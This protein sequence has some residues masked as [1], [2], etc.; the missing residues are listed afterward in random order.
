[1]IPAALSAASSVKGQVTNIYGS[2]A[3]PTYF[4]EL[5]VDKKNVIVYI[6]WEQAEFLCKGLSLSTTE[7]QGLKTN[8]SLSQKTLDS[9]RQNTSRLVRIDVTSAGK[10]CHTDTSKAG[11]DIISFESPTTK[12]KDEK[13]PSATEDPRYVPVR[14]P[15]SPT[16]GVR[17]GYAIFNNPINYIHQQRTT[18]LDQQPTLRENGTIKKGTGFSYENYSLNYY[19]NDSQEIKT[20]VQEVLEQV[21]LN[22]FITCE[23]G[24]FGLKKGEGDIP[25]QEFVVQGV[26][27]ATIPKQPGSLSVEL[28]MA[29][30]LFSW[31]C[32]QTMSKFVPNSSGGN[33]GP[34]LDMDD[35]I[36]WPLAKLWTKTR[37]KSIYP[38]NNSKALDGEFSLSIPSQ[39]VVN[40]LN[41]LAFAS[42]SLDTALDYNTLAS[43]QR[44]LETDSF[45][46]VNKLINSPNLKVLSARGH[47]ADEKVVIV[48]VNSKANFHTLLET[49]KSLF[50]GLVD[51]S[52]YRSHNF[53][54][55][56]GS[57]LPESTTVFDQEATESTYPFL[58][59][60]A[61]NWYLDIET[62]ILGAQAERAK[63]N[64]T[65]KD[66][67]VQEAQSRPWEFFALAFKVTSMDQNKLLPQVKKLADIEKRTQK[68]VF[69][70][71]RE[72]ITDILA[73]DTMPYSPVL[74]ANKEIIIDS[75]AGTRK[76]NVVPTFVQG[77]TLPSFEYLGGGS[78]EFVVRGQVFSLAAKKQI[79]QLKQ[80]FDQRSMR[81]PAGYGGSVKETYD[82]VPFMRVTNEV[83]D[84]F[85]VQ[86]V[87]P[88]SVSCDSVSEE[89]GVW[90]FELVLL[91]Y[92][93]RTQAAERIKFLPTTL[94]DQAKVLNY[95]GPTPD[96]TS[97]LVLK[98]EEFFSL[99]YSLSQ[100]EVYPD[101]RLP[102]RG[103]VDSWVSVLGDEARR[104]RDTKGA[105][106]KAP[107][108]SPL[109]AEW[110]EYCQEFLTTAYTRK[111]ITKFKEAT[112]FI[113]NGAVDIGGYVD[114]DFYLVYD[115]DNSW[116]KLLDKAMGIDFGKRLDNLE[117]TGPASGPVT[118]VKKFWDGTDKTGVA[119]TDKR[120]KAVYRVFDPLFNTYTEHSYKMLGS[121]AEVEN[122]Y[123]DATHS[124]TYP[125]ANR[126]KGIKVAKSMG[127]T[128]EQHPS[129]WWKSTV[130]KLDETSSSIVD[131]NPEYLEGPSINARI[132]I[133][134][135]GNNAENNIALVNGLGSDLH[136]FF[137]LKWRR[138]TLGVAA[139]EGEKYGT[140][141]YSRLTSDKIKNGNFLIPTNVYP[142]EGWLGQAT[143]FTSNI[144]S[145][146]FG[147]VDNETVRT[148]PGEALLLMRVSSSVSAQQER[149]NPELQSLEEITRIA[150][151]RTLKDRKD[152]IPKAPTTTPQEEIERVV[153][154]NTPDELAHVQK[155]LIQ[156]ANFQYPLSNPKKDFTKQSIT[157]AMLESAP[158][159]D[160]VASTHK[161]DP[162]VLRAFVL[163]R[164]GFGT[165]DPKVY[166]DD[167]GFAFLSREVVSNFDS[168]ESL[169]YLASTYARYLKEYNNIPTI[170]LTATYI[171]T[172]HEGRKKWWVGKGFA[173]SV[174]KA[175]K[176]GADSLAV[177]PYGSK[178]KDT[179]NKMLESIHLGPIM[180]EFW[181]G[182]VEVSR[183]L[184]SHINT[185]TQEQRDLFF[186]P[187]NPFILNDVR[188]IQSYVDTN[189]TPS[190]T[191]IRLDMGRQNAYQLNADVR[192]GTGK[193][194]T[195]SV[196][197][198]A[199]ARVRLQFGLSPHTEAALHGALLDVRTQGAFGRFVQAFPAHK[200][201]IINEG[202]FYAE[203][204]TKLWDQFYTRGGITSIEVF[205]SKNEPAH[206]AFVTFSNM[207][208]ALTRYTQMEALKQQISKAN[209]RQLQE[210]TVRGG[211]T[212]SF[213][214]F[215]HRIWQNMISKTPDPE[216][217]R[218]WQYNHLQQLA[219]SP[220]ARVQ[221]RMGYGSNA[222]TFPIVFNGR[223][224]EV[225]V[226]HG[227]VTIMAE[228]D[229]IELEKPIT[230]HLVKADDGY[231]YRSYVPGMWAGAFAGIGTEPAYI[232]ASALV[233]NN[234]TIAALTQGR[235]G[236]T[237]LA[238]HFGDI[239]FDN[240]TYS[241]PELV[242]NMYGASKKHLEQGFTY[243]QQAFNKNGLYN[244]SET[245]LIS[246]SV[247]E[248]TP[249]KTIQVCRRAVID[250]VASV[251]MFHTRST[252]FYG[253][254][255]YPFNYEFAPSILRYAPQSSN[256]PVIK[257]KIVMDINS[258]PAKTKVFSMVGDPYAETK[259]W[260]IE[261]NW[262]KENPQGGK[263]LRVVRP[264]RS[265]SK[266]V[267]SGANFMEG[268]LVFGD[269][270]S[271]RYFAVKTWWLLDAGKD[272]D[273][274]K[275]E[276]ITIEQ[277]LQI[278]AGIQQILEINKR[279]FDSFDADRA[280]SL[281]K[282]PAGKYYDVAD[283]TM[284]LEVENYVQHL[285]WKP[286]LQCWPAM[287]GLNLVTNN[288]SLDSSTVY[289]DAKGMNTFNGLIHKDT[290]S[291]TLT[292]SVDSDIVQAERRTMMV[293]TGLYVTATQANPFRAA[294]LA[295]G[296]WM[297]VIGEGIREIPDTPA[298]EN[299]VVTS[300]CD[301]VRTMY[302]GVITI[303]G[304][305]GIRPNHLVLLNDA[306]NGLEGPLFVREVTHVMN[307]EMGYKTLITPDCVALP[308]TSLI[309]SNLITALSMGPLPKVNQYLLGKAASTLSFAYVNKRLNSRFNARVAEIT[310]NID[311]LKDT[312]MSKAF[313]SQVSKDGKIALN[314][315]I[316]RKLAQLEDRSLFIGNRERKKLIQLKKLINDPKSDA[317]LFTIL[318]RSKEAGVTIP[319]NFAQLDAEFDKAAKIVLEAQEYHAT[320]LVRLNKAKELKDVS[321][322]VKSLLADKQA[323][324]FL[325]KRLEAAQDSL[326]LTAQK[327]QESLAKNAAE[328]SKLDKQIT[329]FHAQ[330]G[331]D[332]EKYSA[333]VKKEYQATVKAKEAATAAHEKL[334]A[335]TPI[336]E[337]N[338]ISKLLTRTQ[339]QNILEAD[340]LLTE[341]EKIIKRVAAAF[342]T[343]EVAE[344]DEFGAAVKKAATAAEDAVTWKGASSSVKL[345]YA[346]KE[347]ESKIKH[348]KAARAFARMAKAITKTSSVVSFLGPQIILRLGFEAVRL[349][350][351]SSMIEWFNTSL[352]ARQCVRIIPLRTR[353][354]D[355]T[356]M[357]FVAGIRGH[358]GAV[359]GD[360]PSFFDSLITGYLGGAI[361]NPGARAL[362]FLSA[363][364]GVEVPSYGNT[365]LD[366][367]YLREI[368]NL[369]DRVVKE[370][371][372]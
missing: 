232:I 218:L 1:M 216:F 356:T 348:E 130:A 16:D 8:H 305:A 39:N 311:A 255:W 330:Y 160:L 185:K 26:T 108:T 69:Q 11:A 329:N 200:V 133:V 81:N 67:D 57:F 143:G 207:F 148:L 121:A 129:H 240:Q 221:I 335:L 369:P 78:S 142:T 53:I 23:G 193:L 170:A 283:P 213:S 157:E 127:A 204:N 230:D 126:E 290:V 103:E 324:E 87:M 111:E 174:Q 137:D 171:E 256:N 214:N 27:V 226:E 199:E 371:A 102:T 28:S 51:W 367:R 266:S 350:I 43:L 339:T 173:E 278:D 271:Q 114:P 56:D 211:G 31:Y 91:E 273:F 242:M 25:H 5:I 151:K 194:P 146:L 38:T 333:E 52:K 249:W 45:E 292:F 21:L 7:I 241:I 293:D 228:G 47:S 163:R 62:Y 265:G 276:A 253:K 116:G 30:F 110:L 150:R 132:P 203:G 186:D 100:E 322:Q 247:K 192:T 320:L 202:F 20:S 354:S 285:K 296:S 120:V 44:V 40:K 259:L 190:G 361:D 80:D 14:V 188:S 357:P 167:T 70:N 261:V 341:D 294:G 215:F 144:T 85:G 172:T 68:S 312:G 13:W 286:Y 277:A 58:A 169:N 327:I 300:L 284:L 54:A 15:F 145:L 106:P 72:Q 97:P 267:G 309:S 66:S 155:T 262:L 355:G 220:G 95:Q 149:Q 217:L 59:V 334:D 33:K 55:S 180:D 239:L 22:P 107:T 304:M 10:I 197:Q 6:T 209:T 332:V 349:S 19:A 337:D 2:N 101:L 124:R 94:Q 208:S 60:P 18:Y 323:L 352:R 165:V 175:L 254:W 35:M 269:P 141:L 4:V 345:T 152:D 119:Q 46:A 118:E 65:V 353:S 243:W 159:F 89:P 344:G 42:R 302:Q 168:K 331:A 139:L 317:N 264:P 227:S 134:D 319:A 166:P 225:P 9:L 71:E 326:G 281:L 84:L 270:V 205:Q 318:L 158:L 370:N 297:P 343:K 321:P 246:V 301:S 90:N 328:I 234:Q 191:G 176:R 366:S 76:N 154:E 289:T 231:A 372:R 306:I 125:V 138:D 351:G 36:C 73:S 260:D 268:L 368:S 50:L 12:P 156:S 17:I 223:V 96:Q 117:G 128:M 340:E 258:L 79:E 347:M 363:A 313:Y 250:F 164:S 288:I 279:A 179:I 92:D 263:L 342:N 29:P 161:V 224:M 252:L 280:V 32:P 316:D 303:T 61:K 115:S 64:N 196:E 201:L 314:A 222:A 75:I 275:S 140:N 135:Q 123:Y 187:F 109:E 282:T 63:T 295:V 153:W 74:K 244:W 177:S 182:Y 86:F 210:D 298:V 195:L 336:S 37:S 77:M 48:K 365:E 212:V 338:A 299:S 237:N 360:D 198:Q 136:R 3:L 238:P 131:N 325:E 307:M 147:A 88:M 287:T 183:V 98:A 112:R 34:Q 184:G 315:E 257:Q 24:P 364:L 93:P 206:K 104:L 41:T 82:S 219:L 233:P 274:L 105:S 291:K 189:L 251:E 362:M 272:S 248:P 83:F 162:N 99:Q 346:L 358:Q 229:G 181:G 310:D 178:A 235:F 308:S 122:E 359:V 49:G 236:K 113:E 245:S